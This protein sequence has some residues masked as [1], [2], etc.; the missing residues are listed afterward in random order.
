[1]KSLRGDTMRKINIALLMILFFLGIAMIDSAGAGEKVKASAT[2]VRTKWQPIQ[3]NDEE[4]HVIA[5]YENTNVYSKNKNG[6]IPTGVSS[7]MIDMNVKTGKGTLKG[8]VV[9]TYP[10]GD[11]LFTRTEGQLIGNGQAEGTFKYVG[12]TGNMEG[13]KGSGIWK[14]KSLGPG[15]SFLEMEGEREIP[16]K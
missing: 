16:G 5:V 9:S 11:K 1:M 14:S 7:G 13:T 10:N 12:G 8:Y 4:G 2:S 3:V 15:I 6:E